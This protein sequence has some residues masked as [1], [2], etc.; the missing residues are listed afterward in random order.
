MVRNASR[1]RWSTWRIEQLDRSNKQIE[2]GIKNHFTGSRRKGRFKFPWR[3]TQRQSVR[4]RRR[5]RGFR[6]PEDTIERGKIREQKVQTVES[7]FDQTV[8]R[9]TVWYTNFTVK[10]HLQLINIFNGS[11][12]TAELFILSSQIHN[13]SLI[14]EFIDDFLDI[15]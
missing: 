12:K 3:R 7:A 4:S 2:R 11:I 1:P 5:V 13:F 6:G 10:V 9:L 14:A 8:G 15:L